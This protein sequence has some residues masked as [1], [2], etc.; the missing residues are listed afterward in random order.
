MITALTIDKQQQYAAFL[1]EDKISI[2]GERWHLASTAIEVTVGQLAMKSMAAVMLQVIL[3]FFGKISE[4]SLFISTD[5]HENFLVCR[6]NCVAS[7]NPAYCSLINC[8]FNILLIADKNGNDTIGKLGRLCF[9]NQ[10]VDCSYTFF[11]DIFSGYILIKIGEIIDYVYG[12]ESLN[13]LSKG[14]HKMPSFLKK[15]FTKKVQKALAH[16][17]SIVGC[18]SNEWI[19]VCEASRTSHKN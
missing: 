3:R 7:H 4:N 9:T 1:W 14:V 12:A 10:H 15:T 2:F 11:K 8:Q 18:S 17:G 16:F 13:K 19:S 6:D 5:K